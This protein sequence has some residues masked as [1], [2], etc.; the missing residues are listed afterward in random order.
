MRKRSFAEDSSGMALIELALVTPL[1]IALLLGAA[2]YGRLCY[3]GMEVTNAAHAG[4]AY[5]TQ[6]RNNAHQ[7]AITKTVALNEESNIINMSSPPLDTSSITV[8]ELCASAYDET[9]GTC[10]TTDPNPVEWVRVN[11]QVTV[12]SLFHPYGDTGT[13]TLHG[14]AMMRVR[15]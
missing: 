11:T 8:E 10:S 1:L 12:N 9:P 13:Y 15:G 2:E 5:A 7:T 4:V 6:N 14:S 3:V